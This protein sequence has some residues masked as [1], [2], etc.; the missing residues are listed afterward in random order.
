MSDTPPAGWTVDVRAVRNPWARRTAAASSV[1]AGDD[2]DGDAGASGGA[3]G[4]R[5]RAAEAEA[6]GRAPAANRSSVA[7]YEALVRGYNDALV[8]CG[9]FDRYIT[10]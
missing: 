2:D 6:P 9:S 10:T 8:G 7:A 1:V 5:R 3:G 4:G